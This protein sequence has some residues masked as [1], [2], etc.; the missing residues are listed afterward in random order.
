LW[1]FFGGRTKLPPGILRVPGAKP[2]RIPPYY[3]KQGV[4]ILTN[5]ETQLQ[6]EVVE[7]PPGEKIR[8]TQGI[9]TAKS[10][11]S[12]A[13]ADSHQQ[14]YV[15]LAFAFGV[16][17]IAII[18]A[19]A[20]LIPEPTSFQFNIF[21]TVLALAGAGVAA[22]IPGI[23]NVKISTWITAG[24]ALAVFVVLFFYSPASL[25]VKDIS[26]LP[27]DKKDNFGTPANIPSEQPHPQPL[28]NPSDDW[29]DPKWNTARLNI[30]WVF[31]D[32][33]ARRVY[34]ANLSK[35]KFEALLDAQMHSKGAYE[36]ISQYG[37]ER[38]EHYLKSIGQ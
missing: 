20:V 1:P 15:K 31:N 34:E 14:L 23:L 32:Q 2:G 19:I 4:R 24:G 16:V 18:L 21:K 22:V 26:V 17:F 30:N 27:K 38:T 37:P 28:A 29:S 7:K 6:A 12:T 35:G 3:Q 36:S 11:H 5:L 33:N 8:E 10:L 25:A 13:H 9:E